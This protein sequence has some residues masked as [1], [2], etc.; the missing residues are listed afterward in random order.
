MEYRRLGRTG[1]KVSHL[2]LGTM[3]FGNTE[4]GCDEATSVEIIHRYLAAG[5]NLIDV[6]DIY[7]RG[8]S[9]VITGK[10]IA[11]RRQA[12]ILATKCASPMGSGPNDTGTSRKHVLEAVDASLARL[13]TDYIDLYQTHFHDDTT[14]EDETLPTLGVM[15]AASAVVSNEACARS[16]S[17]PTRF[18]SFT[19]SRPI[20]DSPMSL[21]PSVSISELGATW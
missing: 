16:A 5:G 10:A 12:V 7:A 20:S 17:N 6:A 14:P 9:E 1:L 11:K 21:V 13:G 3:T 4:W 19:V 2:C 18:I 15:S 8:Q